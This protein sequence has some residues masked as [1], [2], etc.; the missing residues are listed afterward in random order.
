MN[1]AKFYYAREARRVGSALQSLVTRNGSALTKGCA[2]LCKANAIS[3]RSPVQ[4]LAAY[5]VNFINF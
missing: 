2:E 4:W 1:P 3:G 5:P